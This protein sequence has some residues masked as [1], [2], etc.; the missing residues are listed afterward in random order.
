MPLAGHGFR[1]GFG[2]R[3]VR[4][5]AFGGPAAPPFPTT[6]EGVLV[7]IFQLNPLIPNCWRVRRWSDNAEA[8]IPFA[9]GKVSLSALTAFAAGG[10]TSCVRWYSQNFGIAQND[11][12]QATAG[13]QPLTT[14]ATGA[15]YIGGT[16]LPG[17]FFD[18]VMVGTAMWMDSENTFPT[19]ARRSALAVFETPPTLPNNDTNYLCGMSSSTH[20]CEM[21]IRNRDGGTLGVDGGSPAHIIKPNG[22][23]TLLPQCSGFSTDPATGQVD[24]STNGAL[25]TPATQGTQDTWYT[26]RG[27]RLGTQQFTNAASGWKGIIQE[28]L[29]DAGDYTATM[30]GLTGSRAAAFGFI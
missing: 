14:D 23:S 25:L 12:I 21:F 17:L 10:Y 15:P 1:L 6:T 26:N 4:A 11:F 2:Y 5:A 13:V 3:G 20:R 19:T 29:F 8:D 22:F 24:M 27:V 16:G 28:F 7:S 30:Q 9:S 18:P